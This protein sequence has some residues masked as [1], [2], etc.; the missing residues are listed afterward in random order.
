[1]FSVD[2]DWLQKAKALTLARIQKDY[3]RISPI[4]PEKIVADGFNE[5]RIYQQLQRLEADVGPLQGKRLLEVGCGNGLFITAAYQAGAQAYGV[6]PTQDGFYGETFAIAKDLAARMGMQEDAIQD[7]PGERLPFPPNSFDV[8][9]SC[10]VLEHV[11]DPSV[12]LQE[13]SRVLKPGGMLHLT[14]PNYGSFWEGHYVLFWIP[15]LPLFLAKVYVR[16]FGRDPHFLDTLKFVNYFSLRRWLKAC[17]DLVPLTYGERLFSERMRM[18][19]TGGWSGLV[20]LDQWLRW[21]DRLGLIRLATILLVGLKAFTPIV[22]LARK[23][24]E[25]APS[26]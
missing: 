3:A 6:E 23:S 24:S 14:V 1:M 16:L 26:L 15:Y 9:Y 20:R 2:Q 10:N 7:A 13:M 19:Q 17:P 11:Q 4:P 18:R 25:E 12:V 8:V 22:L 5:T 21:L